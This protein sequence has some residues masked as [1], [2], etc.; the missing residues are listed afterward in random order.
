MP[1]KLNPDRELVIQKYVIENK[2]LKLTAK[3]LGCGRTTLSRYLKS[4]GIKKRDRYAL[5]KKIFSGK[6]NPAFK[7]SITKKFLI[8][9]YVEN[10]LSLRQVGKLLGCDVD[11]V[12]RN[13]KKYGIPTRTVKE[14]LKGKFTEVV[15][16][17]FKHKISKKLLVDEYINKNNPISRIAEDLCCDGGTI[18]RY[19]KIYN[20]PRRTVSEALKG[21]FAGDKNPMYGR[22]RFGIAN[23]RY[24]DGRKTANHY[25]V[26]CGKEIG[27]TNWNVGNRRCCSCASKL[28]WNDK[29]FKERVITASMLGRQVKPNKPEKL[30]NGLLQELLL[31]E[32][33]FVGDG[34]LIIDGFCPDFINTNGQKKIIELYGDYWHNKKGMEERDKRRLTAYKKYGYKTLIVWENELKDINKLTDK[35][36]KFNN[37]IGQVKHGAI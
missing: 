2:S 36:I 28:K 7:Y 22:H 24:I 20:I 30:L 37:K 9:E 21:K 33:K 17:R 26:D 4:Y 25:C 32:Y 29:E 15:S 12:L 3:E 35:L 11:T 34:K 5:H 31:K 8:K 6:N 10:S 1:K 27:Y 18:H 16:N 23:P 14:A 19:L 13:I